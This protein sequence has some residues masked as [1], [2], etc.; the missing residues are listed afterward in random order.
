MELERLAHR[1][2]HEA[3]RAYQR[4]L[5][6]LLTPESEAPAE[7]VREN[8]RP[9]EQFITEGPDVGFRQDADEETVHRI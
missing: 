9:I 4:W 5:D 6:S 3:Q 1:L 7:Q 8:F 2:Q